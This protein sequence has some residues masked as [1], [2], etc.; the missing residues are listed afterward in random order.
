MATLQEIITEL[1]ENDEIIWKESI[2]G[3]Y[4]ANREVRVQR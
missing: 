3:I 2:S 4:S 1:I